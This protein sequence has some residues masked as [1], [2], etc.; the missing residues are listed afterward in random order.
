MALADILRA[1]TE[2]ANAE[3]RTLEQQFDVDSQDRMKKHQQELHD[4]EQTVTAQKKQKMHHLQLKAEGHAKMQTRHALLQKKQ[5][6]LEEVYQH[7]LQKLLALDTKSLDAFFALCKETAGVQK[8]VVHMAK[9]HQK[10]GDTLVTKELT[11][12][13]SI[14]AKGGFTIVTEEKVFNFTFEFLVSELLRPSTEISLA[15]SLFSV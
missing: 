13:E 3:L 2:E 11:L 9:A 12:G 7:V 6:I 1:I 8:G 15:S 10:H 14:D 4:I 5:E